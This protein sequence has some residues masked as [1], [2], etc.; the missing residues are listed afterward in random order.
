MENIQEEIIAQQVC[1]SA[2]LE[3]TDGK[4]QV[5]NYI[6]SLFSKL[7]SK[8]TL[9]KLAVLL[10]II[11]FIVITGVLCAKIYSLYKKFIT[12]V[13]ITYSFKRYTYYAKGS[14]ITPNEIPDKEQTP[15]KKASHEQVR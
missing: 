14:D 11:S 2:A 15:E 3:G 9:Y 7:S 4:Y 5:I 8:D 6:Y 13:K 1:K 10:V 12:P